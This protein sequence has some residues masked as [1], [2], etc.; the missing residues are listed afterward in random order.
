MCRSVRAGGRRY[1]P[2]PP[3]SEMYLMRPRGLRL[4]L[5]VLLLLP[6]CATLPTGPNV[7]VLPGAGTSLEAFQ[8]DDRE[9]QDYAAQQ[10]PTGAPAGTRAATLQWRYDMA[11]VQCMYA[12]GHRVPDG[13]RPPPPPQTTPP[14]LNPPRS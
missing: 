3:R 6:A 9:C 13:T 4:L 8:R 5:G 1:P 12:K 7:L 11:Y 10:L 14:P 2:P